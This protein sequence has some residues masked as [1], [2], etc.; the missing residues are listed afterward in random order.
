VRDVGPRPVITCSSLTLVGSSVIP[1]VTTSWELLQFYSM[2]AIASLKVLGFG[3]LR[4]KFD[5]S[6]LGLIFVVPIASHR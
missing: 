4:V 3:A 5:V 6:V 2:Y 1:T